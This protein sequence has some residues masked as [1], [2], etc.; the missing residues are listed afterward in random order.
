[1]KALERIKRYGL[2]AYIR[3]CLHKEPTP[4]LIEKYRKKYGEKLPLEKTERFQT[5]MWDVVMEDEETGEEV[6]LKG[7]SSKLHKEPDKARDLE[8]VERKAQAKLGGSN[9]HLIDATYRGKNYYWLKS[10]IEPEKEVP[11]K[12]EVKK[13]VKK[14]IIP[15]EQIKEIIEAGKMAGLTPEEIGRMIKEILK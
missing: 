7:I 4:E 2:K 11:I 1:L 8:E 5:T 9:W 12:K 10:E 14:E 13:E 6:E 15:K 3:T